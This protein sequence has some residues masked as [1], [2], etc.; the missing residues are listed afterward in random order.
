VKWK[1]D[2]EGSDFIKASLLDNNLQPLYLQVWGGTNTIA[3]SLK[4]IEDQYKGTPQ[5]SVIY[6][7]VLRQSHHLC[8]TRSG[9]YLS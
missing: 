7:K 3:R 1:K 8:H 6:K 2:T 9:C 5:W 4:A